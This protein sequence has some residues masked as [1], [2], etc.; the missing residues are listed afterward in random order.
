MKGDIHNRRSRILMMEGANFTAGFV[1]ALANA[2]VGCGK[3]EVDG[4]GFAEPVGIPLRRR[5][6]E[7]YRSVSYYPAP[8]RAPRDLKQ[9]ITTASALLSLTEVPDPV[10]DDPHGVKGY[11]FRK[12]FWQNLHAAMRDRVGGHDLYHWHCFVPHYL[13]ALDSL[14]PDARLVLTLWGSDVYR[15]YGVAEYA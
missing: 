3:Y 6:E 10:A 8:P 7:V 12:V 1:T 13:P 4:L 2:I 15:T 5:R 11:L 14:P 9:A